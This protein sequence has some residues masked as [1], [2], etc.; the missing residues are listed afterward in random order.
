MWRPQNMSNIC[1][2][3]ESVLLRSGSLCMIPHPLVCFKLP[4]WFDLLDLHKSNICDTLSWK[5]DLFLI[6]L[7]P[8][9]VSEA[10]LLHP[11]Y[12]PLVKHS[13]KPKEV[14]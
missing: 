12:V 13:V 1:Q 2:R 6:I 4:V 3:K 9:D 11:V 14:K 10:I 7:F 5:W 8:L